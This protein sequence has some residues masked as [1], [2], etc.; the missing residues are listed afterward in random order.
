M[1]KEKYLNDVNELFKKSYVVNSSSISRLIR[2]K[3][4]VKQYQR[5]LI[6]NLILK[7]KIKRLVKGFYTIYDDTSLSVLCFKPAYLGLHDALSFHELWEQETIPIIITSKKIRPGI[8]IILG[9]NVLIKVINKKYL[10]G[11]DYHE[12][13]NFYLPYSDLEKTFIDM[14]YFKQKISDEVIKDIIKK[15]DIN[16]LNSYIKYYP[17]R[18]KKKVLNYLNKYNF[19]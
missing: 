5:H 18:F 10:F 15:I 12:Q 6:R 14:I 9:M 11:F 2:S 17:K 3:K 13:N 16:K 7:K 1:G 8:R 4:N 19:I